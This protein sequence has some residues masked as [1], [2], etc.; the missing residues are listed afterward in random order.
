MSVP[1]DPATPADAAASG[2]ERSAALRDEA[3]RLRRTVADYAYQLAEARKSSEAARD[4]RQAALNLMEDA[5]QARLAEHRENTERRKAED[6]LRLSEA[7]YR[8]L[9]ESID[10]GFFILQRLEDRAGGPLDFRFEE[11]N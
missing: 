3:C 1:K 2:L 10:E 11:A 5:V 6:E 9:F 7:K 4:A 8:T